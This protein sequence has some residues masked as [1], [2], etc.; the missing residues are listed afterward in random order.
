MAHVCQCHIM[1]VNVK[2]CLSISSQKVKS[3]VIYEV[4]FL[5]TDNSGR[6]LEVTEIFL[7]DSQSWTITGNHLR[8]QIAKSI[9]CFTSNHI[10]C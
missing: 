2:T 7:L 6:A 1:S 4:H 5:T 3:S 9:T 8:A 10:S